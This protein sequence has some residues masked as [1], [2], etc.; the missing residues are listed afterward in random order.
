MIDMNKIPIGGSG[1]PQEAH[2]ILADMV[3]RIAEKYELKNG[4]TAAFWHLAV[5]LNMHVGDGLE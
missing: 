5:V 4:A 1:L 2:N 3:A